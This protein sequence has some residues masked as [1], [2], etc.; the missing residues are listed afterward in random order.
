MSNFIIHI[1]APRT[2]TTTLQQHIFPLAK[3]HIV[4]Q[5]KP[6]TNSFRMLTIESA[7]EYL[8][9]N[10]DAI[11]DLSEYASALIFTSTLKL[12]TPG[13]QNKKRYSRLLTLSLIHI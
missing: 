6:K 3:N 8:L 1:G 2:G 5:K 12:A 4:A 9:L 13:E 11:K 7:E 10:K